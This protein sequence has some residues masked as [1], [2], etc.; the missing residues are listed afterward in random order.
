MIYINQGVNNHYSKL[1]EVLNSGKNQIENL[2]L[3]KEFKTYDE[4]LDDDD[5]DMKYEKLKVTSKEN[6]NNYQNKLRKNQG[7]IKLN[8][9]EKNKSNLINNGKNVINTFSDKKSLKNYIFPKYDPVLITI[10]KNAIYNVR[11]ELTNYKEIINKINKEFNIPEEKFENFDKKTHRK[12]MSYDLSVNKSEISKNYKNNN[13]STA[14][15]NF[16]LPEENNNSKIKNEKEKKN[17]FINV[18]K[19]NIEKEK[20]E[21]EKNEESEETKK[22]KELIKKNE[23]KIKRKRILLNALNYL[24]KNGISVNEFLTE[25]PFPTKPYELK[26]SEEF[27]EAVKYNNVEMVSQALEKNERYLFQYDY[28]KQYAYHWAAKLGNIEVLRVLLS[29][30]KD[31]NV[32]DNKMRTPLYLATYFGQSKCIYELLIHGANSQIGDI[33]GKKPIDIAPSKD[34]KDLLFNYVDNKIYSEK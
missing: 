32:Y 19:K 8:S 18:L 15:T 7:L 16:I 34:I 14:E 20:N 5:E 9:N 33:N 13:I 17:S 1:Y 31:C 3:N 10:T 6:F 23:M 4:L 11:N 21:I 2:D 26:D 22:I 30:N 24:S 28:M 25:N 12:V 27:F 29:Y